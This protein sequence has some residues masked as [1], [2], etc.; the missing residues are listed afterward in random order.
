[1]FRPAYFSLTP[2]SLQPR[3]DAAAVAM[4]VGAGAGAVGGR[5]VRAGA[6][7]NRRR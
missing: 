4:S 7:A 3:R 6:V 5:T 2:Q 1:M